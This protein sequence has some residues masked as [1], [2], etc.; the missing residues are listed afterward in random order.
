MTAAPAKRPR[1]LLQTTIPYSADDWHVGRFSR[2][3]D[4]LAAVADVVARNRENGADGNDPVLVNLDSSDFDQVW[5]IAVD[6]GD[7]IT[8]PECGAI[9]RFRD[10]GGHVFVTRDHMD[11]GVSVCN[12]GGIGDAHFFHSRN[13]DPDPSNRVDDDRVTT[14]IH[15]PNFYSGANGDVQT[16]AAVEPV[17]PVLAGVKTLPAHPHEGA[18]GAPPAQP[19]ARVVA[20]G[21]S[22]QSGR[23]FNI[24]VAFDGHDGSGKGWAES[25][26][27]HFVDYNWDVD[28]GCPSFLAEPPSDA[29]A[30]QPH[31]LDD[32]KRYVRNLVSWMGFRAR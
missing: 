4:E 27:H 9:T 5:I 10:A 8:K 16:I 24:A 7:G 18:V 3:R 23:A 30:K 20:R 2:L 17:H 29:I 21:T 28:A 32:T 1:V 25:T 6:T 12:L 31:L 14:S 15:W 22:K 26:F 11:L 19:D 13:P